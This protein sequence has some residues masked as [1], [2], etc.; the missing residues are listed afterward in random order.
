METK[1]FFIKL[2]SNMHVG[3]GEVNYGLIDNLI[4]RDPVTNLPTIN[5]SSL[6]GAL[7]EHFEK[8]SQVKVD[9]TK[10]FGSD[11]KETTK[12]K[13][14]SLR[15]F[16]ADLV[17]LAARCS[18]GDIPFVNVT[19]STLLNRLANLY[20]DLGVSD[21]QCLRDFAS[22][23]QS[24]PE[25]SVEDVGKVKYN[26]NKNR[27]WMIGNPFAK[28]DDK[29]LELLCDDTHLPI[30]T[31]NQLDDGVSNNLFYEQV[32]PRYSHMSTIVMGEKPILNDFCN[33]LNNQ[34]VQIGAH[35][36]IGYGFCQF[37]CYPQPSNPQQ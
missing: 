4:Q 7:R 11:P 32:L 30:I 17:S 36:T 3:S 29:K 1:L 14:G 25:V 6:K 26:N 16:D 37:K 22:L 5:A 31:R 27:S 2:L 21:V 34:I 28:I 18:G 8:C 13:P 35:A 9:V 19:S 20:H 24:N 15:F 10:I 33:A 23:E 12:R